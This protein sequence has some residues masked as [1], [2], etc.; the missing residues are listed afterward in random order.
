M[1]STDL[2]SDRGPMERAAPTLSSPPSGAKGA[3]PCDRLADTPRRH[4]ALLCPLCNDMGIVEVL[5]DRQRYFR[6]AACALLFMDPADHLLP[7]DEVIQY[8][9]HENDDTPAY[10]ALLSRLADP[11]CAVVPH[12]SRGLDYGCGP[13]RV[14]GAMLTERA[15]LTVSYDPLFR[16]AEYLLDARYDFVTCSE[17]AEHAHDPA[18]LFSHLGALVRPGGVIGVMTRFTGEAPFAEWSYRRDPTHVCFY[19]PATMQWIADRHGWSLDV[20]APNVALFTTPTLT[21]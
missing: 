11:I 7:L 6:C 20:P 3:S 2:L 4:D 12:G 16:P 13:T 19:S 10:R 14:L 5:R 8:L 21:A 15:R 17:V 18:A 9:L 1:K